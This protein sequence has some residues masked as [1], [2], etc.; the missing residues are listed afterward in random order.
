MK[1]IIIVIVIFYS[2]VCNS[3]TK[4]KF[5]YD[6]YVECYFDN[7][8]SDSL[9][10]YDNIKGKSIMSLKIDYKKIR[11]QWYKIAIKESRNG[12][13]KIQN[14]MVGP[15][16]EDSINKKLASTFNMWVKLK[17][18][19]INIA[20]MSLPD[21]LGVPFYQKP[22]LNSELVCK[23]GK[24]LKLELIDTDGLW[25]KVSFTHN[26]NKYTGWIERKNQC[27]Y[28]WTSCPFNP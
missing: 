22:D 12:W 20:D 6:D 9:V 7:T 14:L 28:P 26:K 21:S 27:A 15:G 17:N 11:T 16:K 8:S 2:F 3:Q 18:L 25:A 13:A 23:S 5:F 10:I 1:N 4:T 24:F 19:K